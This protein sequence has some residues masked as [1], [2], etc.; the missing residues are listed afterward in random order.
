LENL[1]EDGK[2]ILNLIFEKWDGKHGVDWSG[3]GWG[4]VAGSCVH[5][6][7]HSGLIKCGEFLD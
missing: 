5:G 4:Q 2:I 3:S 1:G 6:N 7:E